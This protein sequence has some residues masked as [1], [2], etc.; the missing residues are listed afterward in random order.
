[1][2]QGHEPE[3]RSPGAKTVLWEAGPG[4][5]LE[6]MD[7]GSGRRAWRTQP[8]NWSWLRLLGENR[9]RALSKRASRGGGLAGLV[10]ESGKGPRMNGQDWSKDYNLCH[11]GHSV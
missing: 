3:L 9:C 6:G 1:M 2:G 8:Q 5:S 11:L 7:L 4:R 10:P